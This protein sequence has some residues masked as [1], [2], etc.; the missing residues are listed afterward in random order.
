MDDSEY[1]KVCI[2][3]LKDF[4]G[5]LPSKKR[6]IRYFESKIEHSK[7]VLKYARRAINVLNK[8]W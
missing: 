1:Y 2:T 3:E 8:F 4:F 5:K 6:S 7:E